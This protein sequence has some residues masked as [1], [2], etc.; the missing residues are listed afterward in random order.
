MSD[1]AYCNRLVREWREASGNFSQSLWSTPFSDR[2]ILA[3]RLDIE[4]IVML[5]NLHRTTEHVSYVSTPGCPRREASKREQTSPLAEA[6]A[7]SCGFLRAPRMRPSFVLRGS[8]FVSP[9][10]PMQHDLRHF[11]HY[12]R[13]EP[14][15]RS[16]SVRQL[17]S[18]RL[19]SARV[20]NTAFVRSARSNRTMMGDGI[21]ARCD[22]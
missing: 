21:R 7:S 8:V 13:G 4:N 17:Y 15:L 19:T 6:A 14:Q 1:C 18:S 12:T 10:W 11:H 20:H 16:A 3:V 22:P 9:S 5:L 2:E